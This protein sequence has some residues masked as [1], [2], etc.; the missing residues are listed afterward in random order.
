IV[1]GSQSH[2]ITYA[3]VW[4]RHGLDHRFPACQRQPRLEIFGIRLAVERSG[5]KPIAICRLG[6]LFFG[7]GRSNGCAFF[8]WP[9]R[10][11]RPLALGG[12]FRLFAARKNLVEV[13]A[14]LVGRGRRR[15]MRL[16]ASRA[17]LSLS[18]GR[19][20]RREPGPPEE[21]SYA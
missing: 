5:L 19:E 3:L 15:R 4:K 2:P 21:I 17:L 8:R 12:R 20:R 1:V 7:F 13:E 10:L 16:G 9:L 11:V 18:A 6:L 14:R